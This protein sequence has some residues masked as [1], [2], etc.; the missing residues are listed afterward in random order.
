[1]TTDSHFPEAATG[2]PESESETWNTS[3]DTQSELLRVRILDEVVSVSD[4]WPLRVGPSKPRSTMP[5]KMITD[6]DRK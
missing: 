1:M 3:S 6:T 4:H 5:A 2:T